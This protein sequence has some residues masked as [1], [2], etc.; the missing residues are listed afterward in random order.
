MAFDIDEEIF[1]RSRNGKRKCRRG[2]PSCALAGWRQHDPTP[3]LLLLAHLFR[4]GR[5]E[6]DE[7]RAKKAP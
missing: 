3:A 7:E 4:E 2:A 5:E 1:A 6:D